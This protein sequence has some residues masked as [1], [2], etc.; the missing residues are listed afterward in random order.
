L[1]PQKHRVMP[2]SPRTKCVSDAP[3]TDHIDP[4]D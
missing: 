2:S 1:A 3:I 4:T